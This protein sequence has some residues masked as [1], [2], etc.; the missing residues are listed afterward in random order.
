MGDH[1]QE[2]EESAASRGPDSAPE[3]LVTIRRSLVGVV[4][5][6]LTAIAAFGGIGVAVY[7]VRTSPSYLF[8]SVLAVA[9]AVYTGVEALRA[10]GYR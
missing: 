4:Y 9:L 6:W 7:A 5:I 1:E 10:F 3:G 2:I 8:V